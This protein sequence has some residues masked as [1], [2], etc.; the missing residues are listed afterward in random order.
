MK[1]FLPLVF[2]VS[3][4]IIFQQ[5]ND[6][7]DILL[8]EL[9]TAAI[10]GITHQNA[11]SGGDVLSNG[12]AEVSVRG[13]CWSTSPAP[14]IE[15]DKTEDGTGKG[16]FVSSLANLAGETTYYVRA[17]AINKAGVAYG[18]QVAF[19]TSSTPT[20]P[21]VSTTAITNIT[22]N[23]ASS[24]G[25]IT[26]DGN[27]TVTARG[28][29]WS[30]TTGPTISDTKTSEG[31]GTGEFTSNLTSL[32]AGT[33]YYVRA[34]ATNSIGTAYGNEISFSSNSIITTLYVVKDGTI[35]NNQAGNSANGNYGAGGSELLQVGYN[36]T[37]AIYARALVQFDLSSIPSNA[38][39][40]SVTLQFSTGT[41]GMSVQPI[42][43]YKLTETWIEGT[44]SFCAFSGPCNTAGIA[45]ASGGIDVT[46]NE[47]S[48]SEGA[49]TNP[50]TTLGGVFISTASAASTD[51]GA[52]FLQYSSDGLKN[53][54]QAWV[55]NS[56][57]NFGW[58]LKTEF[59]AMTSAMQRFRSREGAAASGD[60]TTAPKIVV[61]Y[62]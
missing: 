32:E 54:V 55:S 15:N 56:S 17:Y 24:G 7:T 31:T 1:K 30:T 47:R 61:T 57:T 42:S 29:C 8:P 20:L 58:L 19:T 25:N 3:T 41:S 40:E 51:T 35:F 10:T 23:S 38:V 50:W 6:E 12:G 2:V 43:V 18:N 28:I 13:I 26:S 4:L 33:T 9:T 11:S 62:H 49:N 53:D 27:S 22:S 52:S 34:F 46:W 36:P 48:Y 60:A 44:T 16:L 5:C 59:I 14:T 45:I 37:G 39:I 21:I